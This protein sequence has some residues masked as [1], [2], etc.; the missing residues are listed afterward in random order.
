[1]KLLTRLFTAAPLAA[2]L[3]VELSPAQAHQLLHVQRAREGDRVALFNGRDGEWSAELDSGKRSV[4]ATVIEQLRPQAIGPDIWLLFA[5]IKHARL[6]FL[7]E[8]A[9]E[10]GAAVLQPVITERTQIGRVAT[11]KLFETAREAAEQCE[12][13]EV[14]VVEAALPLQ[15]RL[16]DWPPTRRLFLCAEAGEAT[17]AAQA[18]TGCTG[19]A[20]I[21]VGPEGG[22]APAE[23]A[24]LRDQPFVTPVS[25][26]PR[27][28]RAET[29]ALAA[30]SIWQAIAGDSN[31]RSEIRKQRSD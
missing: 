27:I 2:G 5:P 23:L 14:P 10:L 26:G 20:A 29:A 15:K 22:F 19:A 24:L 3:R 7:I 6:D 18:F 21:L 4:G 11:E 1:M 28:L 9:T 16:A 12:R 13:L 8:K 25:L 30:L 31:Q 17:P